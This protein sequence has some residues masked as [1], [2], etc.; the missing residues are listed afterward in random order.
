MLDGPSSWRAR[1]RGSRLRGGVGAPG[2]AQFAGPE[3]DCQE[4]IEGVCE[5]SGEEETVSLCCCFCDLLGLRRVVNQSRSRR[6]DGVEAQ[7]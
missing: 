4:E 6:V 3:E 1:P 5:A 7:N 2:E